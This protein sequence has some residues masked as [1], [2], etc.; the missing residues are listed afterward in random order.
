MIGPERCTIG[1]DP[2][3]RWAKT[4]PAKYVERRLVCQNCGISRRFVPIDE[5]IPSISVQSLNKLYDSVRGFSQEVQLEMLQDQRFS[6]RYHRWQ[7]TTAKT[8]SKKKAG[9]PR[10]LTSEHVESRQDKGPVQTKCILCHDKGPVNYHPQWLVGS[11]F[12]LARTTQKCMSTTCIGARRHW[13]P[14]DE[15]IQKT[16]DTHIKKGTFSVK[17]CARKHRQNLKPK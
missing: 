5:S 7:K 4:I 12:Y 13:I 11:D 6:S 1:I 9:M 17:M 14:M 8:T 15:G 3:P 16:Y 10:A 2:E